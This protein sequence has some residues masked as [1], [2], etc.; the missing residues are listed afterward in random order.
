M[1]IFCVFLAV[2]FVIINVGIKIL[3][4]ILKRIEQ[5]SK[6]IINKIIFENRK[7]YHLNSINNVFLLPQE[8]KIL[9]LRHDKIGDLIISTSFIRILR[10]YNPKARIDILLSKSNISA[11]T[12][13]KKYVDN[14]WIYEKKIINILNLIKSLRRNKYDIII[15]LFDNPST[16]SALLIKYIAPIFAI[17]IDKKNSH[18]YDYTVP[19][20]DRFSSHIVERTANLLLAFGVNPQEEN[21][22]L[23]YD[24]L[25]NPMNK[26]SKFRFGINLA[27]GGRSRFWGRENNSNLIKFIELN[28]YD[29]EIQL[30]FTADYQQD[31]DFLKANHPQ[32]ITKI[33]ENFDQFVAET[34]TC[35]LIISP[36]TSIVHL[37]SA[38]SIP[39]VILYIYNADTTHAPWY[40]YKSKYIAVETSAPNISAIPLEDVANAVSKLYSDIFMNKNS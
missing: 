6:K 21:L 33:C 23:E 34:S 27:G 30:F 25:Q 37:A 10:K 15:D 11:Q 1:N 14:I 18:I 38:F 28:Y 9:L 26:N 13:V 4:K 32:I 16:T 29:S 19:M 12:C 17:G 39:A 3:S 36:D 31:A 2:L 7:T 35:N 5:E 20:L 40:P 24:L 8:R 22:H